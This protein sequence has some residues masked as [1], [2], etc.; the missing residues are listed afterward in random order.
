MKA[1]EKNLIE[2]HLDIVDEEKE[3]KHKAPL[4]DK[5]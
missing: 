1:R 4:Q 3:R 2:I 5:I